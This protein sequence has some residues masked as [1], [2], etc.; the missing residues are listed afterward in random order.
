M[1]NSFYNNNYFEIAEVD[2]NIQK[3]NDGFG[4]LVTDATTQNDIDEYLVL[5]G[6][7]KHSPESPLNINVQFETVNSRKAKQILDILNLLL[8]H[9]DIECLLVLWHYEATD[10]KAYE[11]GLRTQ[12][13]TEINFSFQVY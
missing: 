3:P 1:M 9:F 4:L 6:E 5:A 10:E 2:N 8:E 7:S 12:V 13:L 11:L